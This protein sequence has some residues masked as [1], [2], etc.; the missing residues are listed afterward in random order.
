MMSK[1][2]GEIQRKI[3]VILKVITSAKSAQNYGFK[4][5]K[6]SIKEITGIYIILPNS[7]I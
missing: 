6:R 7:V 1:K 3:S 4:F 2:Y 5:L